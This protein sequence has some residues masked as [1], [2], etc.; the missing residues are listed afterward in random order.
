VGIGVLDL[1]IASRL[2][3]KAMAEGIGTT[4]PF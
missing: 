2:Y 3:K 1:A 4:L